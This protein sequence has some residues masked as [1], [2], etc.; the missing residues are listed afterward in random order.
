MR[1][2]WSI[3]AVLGLSLCAL[4]VAATGCGERRERRVEVIRER[5]QREDRHGH[6][7]EAKVEHDRRGD[8]RDRHEERDRE[9]H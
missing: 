5:P 9:H 1:R 2:F 3:A 4:A 6:E 8:D 7:R